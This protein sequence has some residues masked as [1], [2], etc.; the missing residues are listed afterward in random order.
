MFSKITADF[1][2]MVK[3]YPFHNALPPALATRLEQLKKE[4][5]RATQCCMQ[6][7]H[8][9]NAAGLMVSQ[10]GAAGRRWNGENDHIQGGNG[11]YLLAVDEVEYFLTG[12]AG[13]KTDEFDGT[14]I[15]IDKIKIQIMGRQGCLAFRDEGNGMHTELWT[16]SRILQATISGNMSEGGVFHQPRVL[17]W[18]FVPA[19]P[20]DRSLPS[21]LRGWW[22]VYD[23]NY[24][25]YYFSD[26]PGVFYTKR[27][28]ADASTPP[29]ASVP[30][31]YGQ[32]EMMGE[33]VKLLWNSGTIET[34]T[35]PDSS[36]PGEMYGTSNRYGPLRASKL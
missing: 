22:R 28:P 36:Q 2:T 15:G 17:F 27:A 30:S 9:F 1:P 5:P 23:T 3:H 16:G 35:R 19:T 33:T 10:K 31:G 34:F 8:A 18:E 11:Y 13:N 4:D 12:V 20:T 14:K 29:S 26:Q 32:V 25:W 21:W 24:Y 7:S 6:L